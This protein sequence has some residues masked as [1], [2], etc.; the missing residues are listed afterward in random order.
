[1]TFLDVNQQQ[2]SRLLYSNPV[3]MLCTVDSHGK[4][5]VMTIS[6]LTP[7]DNLG[8][9]VLS[10]NRARFTAAHMSTSGN[11]F[12][13]CIATAAQ[14]AML[15]RIGS[16]SGRDVDDKVAQ[17]ELPVREL[18]DDGLFGI[19]GAAAFLVC[20]VNTSLVPA[21][22]IDD[23]A[24][25]RAF[26]ATTN[27]HLLLH[28]TA[29]RGSVSTSYWDGRRFGATN[30]ATPPHLAFLGSQQFAATTPIHLD[31]SDSSFLARSGT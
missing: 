8:H 30:E 19:D 1:M 22:T 28:C 4:R 14:C 25:A 7:T 5:N 18:G 26:Q 27:H 11:R 10:L 9:F 13:L 16:C 15:L 17:L 2:C 3:C 24:C 29:L 21:A 6:W 12:V 31:S 20:R 23:A